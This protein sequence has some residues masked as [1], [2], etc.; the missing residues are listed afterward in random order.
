MREVPSLGIPFAL[1]TYGA[2]SLYDCDFPEDVVL[3]FGR[4]KTGL[5]T[6]VREAYADRCFK[7]PMYS[8]HVRSMNLSTSVAITIYEVV[9][10]HIGKGLR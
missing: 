5:P 8:P 4:E 3:I 1:E 2:G 10:Q 7:I 9:R 6:R